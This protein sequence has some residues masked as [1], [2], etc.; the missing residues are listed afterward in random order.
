MRLNFRKF[1][2]ETLFGIPQTKK[3]SLTMGYS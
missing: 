2:V 1:V 3:K